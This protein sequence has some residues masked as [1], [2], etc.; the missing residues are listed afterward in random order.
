[1]KSFDHELVSGS[2]FRSVWKLAW[3][4]IMLN[5]MN[6]VHGFV[7]HVLVGHFVASGDNAANA[8]IGVAWQ[9]FLVVVVLIASL[10]HGMNVL[11]SRYAG[12]RDR[13]N[14]SRVAYHSFLATVWIMLG[15]MAP[16][17]YFMAPWLLGL[18]HADPEVRLHALPYIRILFTCG[19][20]IFLMFMFTGAF[21]ASGDV[22][23]PL[24]LGAL[25]TV[26]NVCISA[27]LIPGVRPFDISLPGMDWTVHVPLHIPALG[28]SG[29]AL[30]T[31]LA[32]LVSVIIAVSIIFRRKTLL[33]PPARFTLLP[34]FQVLRAVA[35]IGIPAGI[36]GV[37]LNIGGVALLSFI[38]SL[39]HGSAAQAAYTICYAQLFSLVTWTGLG[40]RS[41]ASALMGQNIGAGDPSRGKAAVAMAAKL[42]FIWAVGV[43]LLFWFFPGWLLGLFGATDE[44]I[45]GYGQSLLHY[46]AFSGLVL[47]AAQA[48][49]GGIQGA[50]QTLLPMVIAMVTQVGVLLGICAFFS[51]RGELTPDRVWGAILASHAMRLALTFA[52]FR[53]SRWAHTKV[54]LAGTA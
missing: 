5:L 14:M 31:V 48:L 45:Y 22:K 19:T 6:G 12:R 17:G 25:A 53:T 21:Q 13:E 40:L 39:E 42:G 26:L 47:V 28:T 44:P 32:P 29:A 15:V 37:A 54:E 4:V 27:V 34:D 8:A 7:D 36:Q 49:T 23:T 1:M 16:L 35:R 3:P 11:V 41:A 50:G 52:L 33:Q 30:G 24:F 18:A 43:G 51:L 46:L 38:G 10:F 20:P 2:V 9:V